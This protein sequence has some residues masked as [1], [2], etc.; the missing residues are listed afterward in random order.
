L[1]E[2]SHLPPL[3]RRGAGHGGGHGS[4]S[5]ARHRHRG[6]QSP[7]HHEAQRSGVPYRSARRRCRFRY[8]STEGETI[9]TLTP[10]EYQELSALESRYAF[11]TK[12]DWLSPS[13]RVD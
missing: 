12:R 2:R 7:D 9:M 10:A 3:P 13:D 5:T 1:L 4:A 8:S 6:V 11:Y